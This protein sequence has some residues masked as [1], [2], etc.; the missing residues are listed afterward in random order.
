MKTN[1]FV[2]FIFA[3]LISSSVM[4]YD[5]GDYFPDNSIKD[6]TVLSQKK[7]DQENFLINTTTLH[8]GYAYLNYSRLGRWFEPSSRSHILKDCESG[9]FLCFK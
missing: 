3:A 1:A 9:P 2:K 4:S 8:L 6:E 5:K 7:L